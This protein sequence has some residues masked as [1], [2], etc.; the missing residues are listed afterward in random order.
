MQISFLILRSVLLCTRG[1]LSIR[2][3]SIALDNVF[4]TCSAVGLSCTQKLVCLVYHILRVKCLFQ[5]RL[6]R[7]F[8]LAKFVFLCFFNQPCSSQF[9][10][11][12]L[13]F[14]IFCS[15]RV[16]MSVKSW[17]ILT[18]YMYMVCSQGLMFCILCRLFYIITRTPCISH[19]LD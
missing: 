16:C 12:Q 6:S 14:K 17:S 5:A 19:A 13:S 9:A 3:D 4:R 11:C 7:L 1:I 15:F 2:K 18:L 10:I 8:I